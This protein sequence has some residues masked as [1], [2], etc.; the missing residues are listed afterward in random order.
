MCSRVCLIA[1]GQTGRGSDPVRTTVPVRACSAR[2]A[3]RLRCRTEPGLSLCQQHCGSHRHVPH[4]PCLESGPS[5]MPDGGR[6]FLPQGRGRGPGQRS[7]QGKRTG[8]NRL[9]IPRRHRSCAGKPQGRC[10]ARLLPARLLPA[11]LLASP[12]FVRRQEK[13][14]LFGVSPKKQSGTG[15]QEHPLACFPAGPAPAA[16]SPT[17]IWPIERSCDADSAFLVHPETRAQK[18]CG[19]QTQC[20]EKI[21]H[22]VPHR[23][24]LQE[25]SAVRKT[26]SNNLIVL[27]E[28]TRRSQALSAVPGLC[29]L[30]KTGGG[31]A[32][33]HPKSPER[34]RRSAS[35]S[36]TELF[37]KARASGKM[38]EVLH[39]CLSSLES[40]VLA[41][42]RLCVLPNARPAARNVPHIRGISTKDKKPLLR[43]LCRAA[44]EGP[45][46]L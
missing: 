2:R 5:C 6:M 36:Q 40:P 12:P 14:A 25:N 26:K 19:P 13:D 23:N 7:G 33:P 43:A 22:E 35:D 42:W 38:R 15:R 16:R 30:R 24:C 39:T 44:K 21:L 32:V 4:A 17:C 31:G 46:A 45:C 41:A 34:G 11:R 18:K 3:C 9:R 27:A 10:S 20:L 28:K 8:D 29:R 1:A 37:P